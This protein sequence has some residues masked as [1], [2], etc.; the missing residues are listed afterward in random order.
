MKMMKI[1]A[2]LLHEHCSLSISPNFI[3]GGDG[4]LKDDHLCLF[5]FR[6][7][8][9]I[10]ENTKGAVAVHCKGEFSCFIQS[11]GIL[12]SFCLCYWVQ[13]KLEFHLT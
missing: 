8:L 12:G 9:N 1:V 5:V 13:R 6:R 7:F 4:E 11:A 2:V 10:A 3:S